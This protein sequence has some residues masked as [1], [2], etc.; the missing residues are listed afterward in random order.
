MDYENYMELYE[1]VYFFDRINCCAGSKIPRLSDRDEIAK[2][3]VNENIYRAVVRILAVN[4]L[5]DYD[6]SRFVMTSE[7]K[8]KHRYILD[9]IIGKNQNNKYADMFDKAAD[10]SRYFFECISELEYEIYSRYNFHLTFETGKEAAKHIDLADK[11]AL[12]LGGNSGGLGTALLSKYRDCLYTIVDTKIPCMVGKE[13]AGANKVNITFIENS[14]ENTG[15]DLALSGEPY[16]YIIMMNLLHDFDDAKCADILR[17]CA[18]YCKNGAKFVIIEDVL[19]GD[20]EPK[21]VIMHGLRLA[22]ECGGGRQRTTQELAGLFSSIGYRPEKAVKIDD[23]HTM[24]VMG[25]R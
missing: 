14:I 24:L 23:V 18:K 13:F 22:V 17:N 12:E 25:V 2:T 5:L 4:R 1:A 19:T 21:E 20:F 7:N 9:N 15:F 11:K 8:E 16:D 6:G 3:G 10:E